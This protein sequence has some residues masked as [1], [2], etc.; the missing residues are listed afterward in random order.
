MIAA[1]TAYVPHRRPGFTGT[2]VAVGTTDGM[3]KETSSIYQVPDDVNEKRRRVSVVVPLKF[4]V[5]NL[6]VYFFHELVR[7][8][9]WND[10]AMRARYEEEQEGR[11]GDD[12]FVWH[13][14][15]RAPPTWGTHQWNRF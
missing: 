13:G 12:G 3:P 11:D 14:P 15:P 6:Y 2:G 5:L 9:N 8:K 4:T 10:D 7:L 1:S